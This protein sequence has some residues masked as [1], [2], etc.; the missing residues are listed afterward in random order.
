MGRNTLAIGL[1]L[2]LIL[3]LS[4]FGTAWAEDAG[5][6]PPCTG[7]TVSGVVWELDLE[8]GLI[9]LSTA[10]GLCQ[11]AF[12]NTSYEH[13]IVDL[14]DQYFSSVDLQAWQAALES[15]QLPIL[16]DGATCELNPGGEGDVG[17]VLGVQDNGDGTFTLIL[18]RQ[19]ET[20]L[21]ISVDDAD[22]AGSL[23]MALEALTGEW[24][25][26]SEDGEVRLGGPG[27]AIGDYHTEGMGFGVLVKLYAIALASE[28]ACAGP[29]EEGGEPC[30]PVTVDEL[31]QRVN[32]GEGMGELFQEYGKPEMLGVGHARQALE[33][34]EHGKPD[35]EPKIPGICRARARGGKG[36]AKGK[37]EIV[38]PTDTGE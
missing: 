32:S 34:E 29:S 5:E 25:L 37:G 15:I 18:L 36:K 10:T 26:I 12:G 4:F 35:K 8:N 6:I 38:C 13:P 16:C 9:T 14:L 20:Q 33:G 19:D 3:A 22:L 2:A 23:T 28:E 27:D 11:V 7:D 21:E 24:S 17:R 30:T 1:P 31:V